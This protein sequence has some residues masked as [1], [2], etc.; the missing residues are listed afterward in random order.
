MKALG[1]VIAA[2]AMVLGA[3]SHAHA[4]GASS[5]TTAP[6]SF[7]FGSQRKIPVEPSV[8]RPGTD[9]KFGDFSQDGGD[10]DLQITWN[11]F[12]RLVVEAIENDERSEFI[13]RNDGFKIANARIGLRAQKGNFFG[14]VS[15]D[16]AVGE[17][18]TFNDPD[19]QLAVRPRDLFLRYR[20][21]DFAT[22]T[23]GRFKAPYDLGQLETTAYRVFIDLPVESRGVLPTQG[24]EIEG[25]GQGR[26]LGA[27]VH[28]DRVGLDPD[29]FDI[30]YALALTNGRTLGLALNDNDRVAGFARMSLFWADVIQVNVAGFLIRAPSAT[31]PNCSTKT[32]GG[33]RSAR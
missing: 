30:G 32:C 14:Y 26:Q 18:E 29:G 31:F 2:I 6:S 16:A 28:S 4:A 13:G 33:S 20:L 19:Q 5:S 27:M 9:R 8:S 23:L 10:S 1:L 3:G 11:G 7:V 21:A 17:R 25:L 12:L 15:V 22:V 24:F